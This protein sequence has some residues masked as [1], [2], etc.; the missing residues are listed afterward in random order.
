[1]VVAA[2]GVISQIKQSMQEGGMKQGPAHIKK[3]NRSRRLQQK[4]NQMREK[5]EMCLCKAIVHLSPKETQIWKLSN[6][7]NHF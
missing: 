2:I 1:M 6:V 3:K 5:H 4:S 7:Q